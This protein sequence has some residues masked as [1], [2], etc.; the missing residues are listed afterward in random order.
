M[1]LCNRLD[2]EKESMMTSRFL[3]SAT[4]RM[5]LASMEMKRLQVQPV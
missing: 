4:G 5:E 1:L 2:E 3:A